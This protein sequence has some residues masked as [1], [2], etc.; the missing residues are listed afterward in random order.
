MFHH[1]CTVALR[2]LLRHRTYTVVNVLGLALALLA[3][4]VVFL[5]V[6]HETTFDAFWLDADRIHRVVHDRHQDGDLSL[7]SAKAFRGM[8]VSLPERVPEIEA[9]TEVF[10]DVASVMYERN[11]IKDIRMYAAEESFTDVF[12]LRFLARKSLRPLADLHSALL[13]ASAARRL[14]GTE[15]AVGKWFRVNE[16]WEFEVTGV[17]QDLP[18]ATHFSFDLLLS[19][20]T[21]R[22][23]L[24]RRDVAPRRGEPDDY[25]KY[26][27]SREVSS[28]E[29]GYAGYY[30]YVK[31]RPHVDPRA[32]ERRID[33]LG[34]EYLRKASKGGARFDFFLQPLRDI[35]LASH[36]T[37]EMAANGD[38]RT[39]WAMAALGTVILALAWINFVNLT[40]ARSL[41]RAKEVAVRKVAGA[42][43]AQLLVQQL[44]EYALVNLAAAALAVAALVVLQPVVWRLLDRRTDL[45]ALLS[46]PRA[47]AAGLGVLSFG[48]LAAGF[49]PAFVQS[50]FPAVQ[51]LRPGRGA[52]SH[53]FDPRR[54][55]VV[56]QFTA[57]IVLLVGV[58]TVHRQLSY[59][60]D[61]KLGFRVEQTLVSFSPMSDIASRQRLGSLEAFRSR[62]LSVPGVEAMTAAS[63]LP[64]R[65]ILW[66]RQDV[67]ALEDA[68]AANRIYDYAYIDHAFVPAFDLVLLAGRNFTDRTETEAA[69]LLVNES[70]ARQLG[71]A[72]PAAA[73]DRFVRVGD[74]K[75]RIVG[76]LRDYHQESLRK[77]LR[78]I[79]YFCG[80]KWM[81]EVGY[82]AIRLGTLDLAGTIEAIRTA[83]DQTYPLDPFEYQFLDDVFDRQYRE[84]RRFGMLCTLFTALAIVVACLGL[85]GL[86]THAIQKRTKE[87]GIRKAHGA[88]NARIAAML[89]GEFAALVG[90]S[91]VL[92]C[93]P[94][95]WLMHG[96]LHSFAY[97]TELN[98]GTFL[99]AGALALAIALGTTGLQAWRAARQCPVQALRYE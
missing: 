63:V 75:L 42:T 94:A 67:K 85:Q 40:L 52:R 44:L 18:D 88:S 61:R 35:H 2:H 47:L 7:R 9:A 98:V 79:L 87:I 20:H 13:S 57:T 91:F 30:T 83:W 21:Y 74:R 95:A 24:D 55:L 29:W 76:V 1:Y 62:I 80:Y 70:A 4:I 73:C 36:R 11:Q 82:Y 26:K 3:G 78:P 46:D 12:A 27:P 50:G 38:P 56:L 14:F 23:Y 90:V 81:Y 69:S 10:H 41:E 72:D 6:H 68:P 43:R 33:A 54:L 93:P 77:E 96:W 48:I 49:Y 60:R 17:F 84:D 97:H 22:Y 86:A 53:R 8:G 89:L 45:W 5:Y 65:E 37:S 16:G 39:V 15:Q 28:W 99:A 31:L 32:V 64:G 59:M 66:Q 25:R 71:F 34:A 51:L 19:R 58:F 92:S